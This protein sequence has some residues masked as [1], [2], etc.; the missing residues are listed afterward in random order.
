MITTSESISQD[1]SSNEAVNSTSTKHNY[2]SE[3]TKTRNHERR[4]HISDSSDTN[5]KAFIYIV[6]NIS[7]CLVLRRVVRW[8]VANHE[9]KWFSQYEDDRH[10]Q[11]SQRYEKQYHIW[12]EFAKSWIVSSLISNQTRL[13]DLE[14]LSAIIDF[15][16]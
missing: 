13:N 2:I 10:Q 11:Q 16:L 6:S 4:S 9:S 14:H 1:L 8:W 12:S 15:S 3:W 5:S 7:T